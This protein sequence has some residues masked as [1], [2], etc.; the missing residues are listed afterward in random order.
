MKNSRLLGRVRNPY[1]LEELAAV[2]VV[3]GHAALFQRNA[4]RWFKT[5]KVILVMMG[6]LVASICLS[7]SLHAGVIFTSGTETVGPGGN[8]SVPITVTSDLTPPSVN[9]LNAGFHL[10][11]DSSVL[12]LQPTQVSLNGSPLPLVLGD[13]SSSAGVLNFTWSAA[14]T[15]TPVPNGSTL[16]AVSFTAVGG[17][18]ISTTLSFNTLATIG[19]DDSVGNN[20]TSTIPTFSAG[21][22]TVVPEPINWA[23]GLFACVC[24]GGATVRWI[25]NRRMFSQG[26]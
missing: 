15:G 8:V 3:P 2:E 7:P 22:V 9:W 16:F 4:V 10:T 5:G 11:W 19:L 25:S 21:G 20:F 24:I 13:F 23:L 6:A 1:W 17:L 18:G 12:I 26:T 14:D